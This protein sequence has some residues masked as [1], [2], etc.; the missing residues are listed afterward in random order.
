LVLILCA[1]LLTNCCRV[2]NAYLQGESKVGKGTV[3]GCGSQY[4][5]GTYA[6]QGQ[7]F[8]L[9]I[10]SISKKVLY[11][12]IRSHRHCLA[13]VSVKLNYSFSKKFKFTFQNIEI[14][15]ADEKD[16][17]MNTGTSL[18]KTFVKLGLDQDLDRQ[19][20]EIRIRIGIKTILIY[21]IDRI[22]KQ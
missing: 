15:D 17:T 21:N 5:R 22:W 11:I 18:N 20:M 7:A 10:F 3:P 13:T 8:T 9:V 1:D 14:Y 6:L 2:E 19:K 4:R 16:E 12:R